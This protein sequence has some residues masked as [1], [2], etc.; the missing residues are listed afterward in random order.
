MTSRAALLLLA[1][2]LPAHA[3]EDAFHHLSL[4][5]YAVMA[6]GAA[7]IPTHLCVSGTVRYVR[8]EHDGDIHVR[9]CDGALCIV[10]EIIPAVPLPRPRKGSTISV[11]GITR[12]D[13]CPGHGWHELHPVLSWQVMGR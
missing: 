5:A 1:F 6:P 4:S 7:T 12:Y 8:K 2:A 3:A 11:C 9:V 10:A 13:G